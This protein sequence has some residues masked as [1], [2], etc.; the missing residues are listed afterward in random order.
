MKKIEPE[1]LLAA[2]VHFGHKSWRVNPKAR[3][4]I[5]KMERGSSIIDLF[6]TA[7]Q[8]QKAKE[9]VFNLA[10]ENKT[11][12]I[13][14]S[15]KQIRYEISKLCS[16]HEIPFFAFKWVGGFL[17]NFDEVVKNI[18]KLNQLEEEKQSGGWSELPKHEIV[19]LEKKINR[20]KK[21]YNGVRNL[22]QVPDAIFIIDIKKEAN[23]VKETVVKNIPTIA[24]VDTAIRIW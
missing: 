10:G 21:V 18:K 4:F 14:A 13:V 2:G 19:Q 5:Y 17:T 3:A 12:L 9:F 6:Q 20:I 22:K 8:L 1:D 23:V 16:E 24:L 15:K 7:D 11:L